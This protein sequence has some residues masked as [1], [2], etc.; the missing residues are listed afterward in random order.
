MSEENGKELYSTQSQEHVK[1]YIELDAQDRPYKVYTAALA[2]TVGSPCE[3]TTYAY[4]AVDSTVII[5]RKEG[6]GV[7][8]QAYQDVIDAM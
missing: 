8:A 4:K 2:H 7:W 1:Q 5:A 6:R 3:V